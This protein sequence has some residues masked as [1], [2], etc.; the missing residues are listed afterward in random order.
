MGL[1]I[2]SYIANKYLIDTTS[3]EDSNDFFFN[4]NINSVNLEDGHPFVGSES[5]EQ[6]LNETQSIYII[7]FNNKIKG[8][9][10][11]EEQVKQVIDD[12]KLKVFRQ[13]GF[14]NDYISYWR[15]VQNNQ[16]E[17]SNLKNGD[18]VFESDF[19]QKNRNLVISYESILY[20]FKIIK[21]NSLVK[22][23]KTQ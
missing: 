19:L 14:S 9:I 2:S 8:F 17:M 15:E 11:T 18:V 20:N 16:E 6:D 13:L 22:K 23:I 1:T 3:I 12:I 21:T 5:V 10:E 7:M 4:N